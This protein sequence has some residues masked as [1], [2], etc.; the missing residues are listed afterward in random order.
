MYSFAMFSH[1]SFPL[2]LLWCHGVNNLSGASSIRGLSMSFASFPFSTD[3]VGLVCR[4]GFFLAFWG[5]IENSLTS[6]TKKKLR[7]WKKGLAGFTGKERCGSRRWRGCAKFALRSR[8]QVVCYVI[9]C[10]I[11]IWRAS[12][13]GWRLR[14]RRCRRWSGREAN[15]HA[16]FTGTFTGAAVHSCER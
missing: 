8:V 13:V 9:G 3:A 5:A 10:I 11:S 16:S 7:G 1:P 6:C 14:G 2:E 15:C 12:F 4:P